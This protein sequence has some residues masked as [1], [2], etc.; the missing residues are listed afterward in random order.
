MVDIDQDGWDD[1]YLMP[2][3]GRNIMLRNQGDGSFVNIAADLGLDIDSFC[4]SALFADFDNDGDADLMLGR[5]LR[6]SMYLE[7]EDGQFVD[8]TS[9]QIGALPPMLVYSVSA[10]DY[11]GDG[12]LDVFFATGAQHITLQERNLV[13]ER[14]SAFEASKMMYR[15]FLSEEKARKAFEHRANHVMFARVGPPNLLLA[16]RGGRFEEAPENEQV[17][18]YRNSTQGTWG[19]YDGDGDPDLYVSNDYAINNMLRNDGDKGF[20]DVTQETETGDIGFGMGVAWGDYNNDK[21]LDLYV[22]NMFSKAGRRITAQVESIDERTVK[23]ANGNTL[24]RND[25]GSFAKVS[26]LKAP[27]LLVEKVG[28]SWGSQ[29]MDVNNDGFLDIYALNGFYTAP[30]EV[31]VAIDL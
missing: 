8:R 11:N 19:D 4:S 12:S 18:L 13:N 10:A 31:A 7:Y 5:T 1:L 28:W 17:E 29:F 21:R 2:R 22:S 23:M 24:F 14:G 9:E 27:K 6:R 16:N 15:E 20:V 26:G 25:E 30:K 3:L